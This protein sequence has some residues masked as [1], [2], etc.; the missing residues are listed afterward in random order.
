MDYE[1]PVSAIEVQSDRT[2]YRKSGDRETSLVVVEND[3]AWIWLR[4]VSR[5]TIINKIHIPIILGRRWFL[6]KHSY[7][8]SFDHETKGSLHLHRMIVQLHDMNFEV[9]HING[10]RLDNRYPENLRIVTKSQNQWNA[11]RRV[12]NSSGCKCVSWH[13]RLKRWQVRI[14]ANGNRK[15]IGY[16]L[17]LEEAKRAYLNEITIHHA[18][19]SRI[20]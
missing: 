4:N 6:S 3:L 5:W 13:K 15:S 7:V 17:T 20:T 9:D 19:Y 11:K 16:F 12:D 18:E 1:P 8:R 14:Q 10:N 2:A